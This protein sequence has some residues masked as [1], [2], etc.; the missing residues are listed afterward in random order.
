M[1]QRARRLSLNVQRFLWKGWQKLALNELNEYYL[2]NWQEILDWSTQHPSCSY[3]CKR[4]KTAYTLV[5]SECFGNSSISC[6]ARHLIIFLLFIHSLSLLPMMKLL[7]KVQWPLENMADFPGF[8]YL[9]IRASYIQYLYAQ[10]SSVKN[11]RQDCSSGTTYKIFVSIPE[12]L[13]IVRFQCPRRC[14]IL[15]WSFSYMTSCT[16]STTKFLPIEDLFLNIAVDAY[17]NATLLPRCSAPWTPSDCSGSLSEQ[18]RTFW[19]PVEH[20]ILIM[21]GEINIY[22]Q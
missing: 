13:S 9:K 21:L 20:T 12:W 19:D 3:I 4:L 18:A 11:I 6:L 14:F 5:C 15:F 10:L 1:L 7:S 22:L 17:L 2:K 16:T 8:Y